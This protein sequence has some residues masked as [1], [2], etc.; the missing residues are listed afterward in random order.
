MKDKHDLDLAKVED[1]LAMLE[2][3]ARHVVSLFGRR[4]A[5]VG[6][7]VAALQE[8]TRLFQEI[9]Q[10]KDKVHELQGNA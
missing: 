9:Q 3:H 2:E 4:L 1:D 6:E 10:I 8:S 5:D 7:R